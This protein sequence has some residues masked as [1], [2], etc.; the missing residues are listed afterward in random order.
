[1]IKHTTQ[2]GVTLNLF[3]MDDSHLANTIAKLI[4]DFEPT[5]NAFRGYQKVDKKL[6]ELYDI[7]SDISSVEYK[8]K[9]NYLYED[10]SKYTTEAVIR[11]SQKKFTQTEKVL[12]SV[13][14]FREYMFVSNYMSEMRFSLPAKSTNKT[15]DDLRLDIEGFIEQDNFEPD[16]F[17]EHLANK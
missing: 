9:L 7:A 10:V 11:I 3:E 4:R 2:S 14:K 5:Y 13:A 12:E 15:I 16:Q 6:L 1:M 17:E 8:S